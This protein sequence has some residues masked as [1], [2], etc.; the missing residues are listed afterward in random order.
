MYESLPLWQRESP[1]LGAANSGPV[2]PEPSTR[3][4]TKDQTGSK[5]MSLTNVRASAG[6]ERSSHDSTAA[7]T[8]TSRNVLLLANYTKS[9]TDP[10]QPPVRD[11]HCSAQSESVG[12]ISCLHSVCPMCEMSTHCIICYLRKWYNMCVNALESLYVHE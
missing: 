8:S 2:Q 11:L 4:A 1:P 12:G 6:L 10:Q 7:I 3:D 9:S 5:R